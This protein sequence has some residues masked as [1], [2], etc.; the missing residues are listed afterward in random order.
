LT[1]LLAST[2]F[3]WLLSNIIDTDT[4]LPPLPLQRYWVTERCGVKI[5]VVGLVEE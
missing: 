2:N 1:K 3:P 5:G 4:G